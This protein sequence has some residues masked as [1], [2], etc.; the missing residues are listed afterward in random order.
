MG[1]FTD[2]I[3][4]ACF[5]IDSVTFN[6]G[7]EEILDSLHASEEQFIAEILEELPSEDHEEATE[8]LQGLKRENTQ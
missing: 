2:V 7:M 5:D 6:K 8:A 3:R 4:D 1:G